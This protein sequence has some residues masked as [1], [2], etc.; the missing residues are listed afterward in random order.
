MSV[1]RFKK[2]NLI[3]KLNLIKRQIRSSFLNFFDY[4]DNIFDLF[5]SILNFSIKS[6]DNLFIYLRRV[7]NRLQIWIKKLI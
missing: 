2:S 6:E 5:G 4:T 3:E 1:K 7:K